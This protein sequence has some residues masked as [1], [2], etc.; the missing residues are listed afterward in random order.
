MQCLFHLQKPSIWCFI[1][2]MREGSVFGSRSLRLYL[3]IS[4][5]HLLPVHLNVPMRGVWRMVLCSFW[6]D[7]ICLLLILSHLGA[8]QSLA[9]TSCNESYPGSKGGGGQG[10]LARTRVGSRHELRALHNPEPSLVVHRSRRSHTVEIWHLIVDTG[11]YSNWFLM[12]SYNV[13]SL[14][15]IKWTNDLPLISYV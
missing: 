10:T 12:F 13:D 2:A 7:I 8:I 15:Y 14:V 6:R 1:L 4:S 5:C 11:I 9:A 3:L